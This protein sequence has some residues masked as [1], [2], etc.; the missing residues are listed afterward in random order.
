MILPW[1]YVQM[2]KVMFL[3]VR[4]ADDSD[5][6]EEITE[7]IQQNPKLIQFI[8]DLLVWNLVKGKT[9]AFLYSIYPK[10]G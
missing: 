5:I 7:K 4:E 6:L 10:I 8:S 9:L 3:F 2:I 1:I